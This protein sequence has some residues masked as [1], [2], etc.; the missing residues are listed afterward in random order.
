MIVKRDPEAP[1]GSTLLQ[2]LLGKVESVESMLGQLFTQKLPALEVKLE[3]LCELL[4]RRRKDNYLVE[5]IAELTGRSCFTVRRW[6]RQ[7]KIRAIRIQDGGPRGRL[8]IPRSELE[9]LIATGKS[10]NLPDAAVDPRS[11][12][13]Q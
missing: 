4:A 5:D 9:R 6:I 7:K 12:D 8:L 3:G 13:E 1:P 2:R 10:V 11:A